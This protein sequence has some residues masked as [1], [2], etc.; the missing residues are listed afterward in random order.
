[1][2][3]KEKVARPE[4]AASRRGRVILNRAELKAAMFIMQMEELEAVCS[5][6]EADM[7][8]EQVLDEMRKKHFLVEGKEGVTWNEFVL[9]VLW[10]VFHS[11]YQLLQ[12][13]PWGNCNCYFH[14]DTI[15][16][17]HSDRAADRYTF[18]WM[19]FIPDAIGGIA[20]YFEA[21]QETEPVDGSPEPLF[22]GEEMELRWP[23]RADMEKALQERCGQTGEKEIQLVS[24]LKTMRKQQVT[25]EALFLQWDEHIYCVTN[26]A[27]KTI[28][29][30]MGYFE[31]IKEMAQQAI[32][33]HG[34]AIS[35][36]K[37]G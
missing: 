29:E 6:S 23:L 33:S 11:E 13:T 4:E 2:D 25:Q 30:R 16:L 14:Q 12:T 21:F 3:R 15:I 1:M 19:P 37:E 7:P 22:L 27:G 36:Q 18:Y 20:A 32:S 5:I 34:Q 31:M 28:A 35:A 10:S 8:D 17:L 9:F 24:E 26:Q